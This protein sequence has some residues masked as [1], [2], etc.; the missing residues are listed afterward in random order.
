[1]I[2]FHNSSI[3]VNRWIPHYLFNEIFYDSPLELSDINEVIQEVIVYSKIPK[4]SI[5]IPLVGGFT[6]S[7]DFAY[8]V[9]NTDGKSTLNLVVEAKDKTELGLG[10]DEAKRIKHAEAFFN[11]V[12]VRIK[13]SFQKQFHSKKIT[14]LIKAASGLTQ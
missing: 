3:T 1:L 11:Q 13:V 7:P 6:Y 14:D 2:P 10:G 9:E 4:N 8:V 12:D 5:R